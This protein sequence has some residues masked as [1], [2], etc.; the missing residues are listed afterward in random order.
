[1]PKAFRESGGARL[2]LAFLLFE[3][4]FRL[5]WPLAYPVA[6]R[7]ESGWRLGPFVLC[8]LSGFLDRM[9]CVRSGAAQHAG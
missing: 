2:V 6:C 8:T 7:A 4:L 9:H 5:W 1:M 3:S